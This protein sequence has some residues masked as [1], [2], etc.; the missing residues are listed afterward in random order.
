MENYFDIEEP[1]K[2]FSIK[3]LFK[4]IGILIIIAIDLTIFIRCV[5]TRD[6]KIVSKILKDDTYIEAYKSDPE[7]FKVLQYGMERSWV[8]VE[9]GRLIEFNYLYHIETAKELQFSVKY[10]KSIAHRGENGEDPFVFRL[11]DDKNNVYDD[12][13]FERKTK[14]DYCYMR[15]CFKDIE[16]TYGSDDDRKTYT[17]YIDKFNGSE[18]KEYCSYKIYNGSKVSKE[19]TKNIEP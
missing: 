3:K 10:N 11:I 2:G 12:Y 13:F 7:N 9:E 5:T 18:Y 1:E 16:L 8:A 19:I 15:M 14:G 4:W 6:D 17:L